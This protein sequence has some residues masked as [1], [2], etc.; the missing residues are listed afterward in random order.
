MELSRQ[1][2]KAAKK[3][4]DSFHMIYVGYRAD[5]WMNTLA[6]VYRDVAGI[7][8]EATIPATDAGTYIYADWP[9]IRKQY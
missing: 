9:T 4:L 8:F 5:E 2:Y 6:R 1:I 3:N 7:R